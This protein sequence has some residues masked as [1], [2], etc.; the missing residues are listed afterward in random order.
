[1]AFVPS[2]GRCVMVFN[3]DNSI[4]HPGLFSGRNGVLPMI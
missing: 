2:P 4:D 1:M 3:C